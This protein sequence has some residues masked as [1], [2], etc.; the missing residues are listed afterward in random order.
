MTKVIFNT[1]VVSSFFAIAAN[2]AIAGPLVTIGDVGT[3]SFDGSAS[4]KMDDNIFRQEKGKGKVDDIVMTFSPG[5]IATLGRDSSN[6]DINLS[7]SFDFVRYQDKGD[8]DSELFHILGEAAYRASRLAVF[9]SANYDESKSNNELANR[10]GDLLERENTGFSI[11]GEYTLSPKFSAKVGLN[12]DEIAYVGSYAADYQDRKNR[13]VP[14]DIFYELTPKLDLSVGYTNGDIDVENGDDATRDDFNVGLRGQ[15][16]PKLVGDF[17]IGYNQ[18][19]SDSY[20]TAS[21]SLKGDFSWTISSKLTHRLNIFR[22][23]DASAT[24]TGTQETKV[25]FSTNY[26]L[27]S[28]VS[29]SGRMGYTIRDYLSS[30]REDNLLTISFNGNYRINT[31]WSV[32]AGY[33]F[34]TNDSTIAS[35]SYDNNIFTLSALLSY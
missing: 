28:K 14:I 26:L 15:L 22:N 18:Y 7:T 6:L 2:F 27:N 16:L 34:S 13:T 23:F 31:N 19:D 35:S 3:V 10:N 25:R 20:K 12:F 11:K 32:N 29:L 33:T 5:L 9:A 1:V 8:L 21:M 30:S 24:G 4:V 17:K